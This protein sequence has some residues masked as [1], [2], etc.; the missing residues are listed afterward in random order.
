[1]NTFIILFFSI[2][3][4]ACNETTPQGETASQTPLTTDSTIAS[5][6]TMT[7]SFDFA[8]DLK[9]PAKSFDLDQDLQEISGLTLSEDTKQICAVQDEDGLLFFINKETGKIEEKIKFHKK[10]DYEGVTTVGKSVYV[11]KSTGTLYEVTELTDKKPKF[12]KYKSFLNKSYEVEGLCHDSKNNRLLMACKAKAGEGD[13][14][15]LTRAIY[16]FDLTKKEVAL[17]PSF[18]VS[19]VEIQNFLKGSDAVKELHRFDDFFD[20]NPREIPFCPSAVAIHP[21]TGNV[22]VLSSVNKI[23]MILSPDSKILHMVK[24]DKKVHVQPEG[25]TFESDGTLYISNE[26]KGGIPRLHRFTYRSAS[27]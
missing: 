2:C 16:S 17:E 12:N 24:L 20:K 25:I 27:K 21:V 19:L 15:K 8:Y 5:K 3:L 10:G 18:L 22:Y 1:M 7:P 13:R 23:L 11:V 14:F 26:G 6:K 4:V 9:Q